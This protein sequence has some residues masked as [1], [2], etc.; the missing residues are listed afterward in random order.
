MITL[1]FS[2]KQHPPKHLQH[3]VCIFLLCIPP[4]PQ[5]G[6][7][8]GSDF[9]SNKKANKIIHK[10]WRKLEKGL[11]LSSIGYSITRPIRLAKYK[12]EKVRSV[13]F[14]NWL[15]LFLLE[16]WHQLMKEKSYS[17][18]RDVILALSRNTDLIWFL[19]LV[20]EGTKIYN[21]KIL[22]RKKKQS[23]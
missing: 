9:Q 3:S 13:E 15:K 21:D 7:M 17:Y 18:V 5:L 19:K 16:I 10:H 8:S 14:M 2:P 23:Q 1:V 22:L 4:T 12:N 20:H 11:G 6:I